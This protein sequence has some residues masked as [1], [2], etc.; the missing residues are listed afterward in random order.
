MEKLNT[1]LRLQQATTDDF[2]ILYH[3]KERS[4]KPYV[5]QIWG[6]DEQVQKDFLRKET[7]VDEVK[8][9]FYR[10]ELAGFVQIRENET[11][12]F[13]G[14]LFLM[15]HFQ[16][17][18]IGA[19]ILKYLFDHKKTVKLEVLKINTRAKK[20]YERVGMVVTDVTELKYTMEKR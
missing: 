1:S 10:K 6:W 16:S 19:N 5:E 9:I 2:D 8:L 12:I 3:I 7:P 20:F 13:V 18:G 4:I 14:S 15:H 17:L 11:E